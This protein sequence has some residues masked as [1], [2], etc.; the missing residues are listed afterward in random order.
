MK[1]VVIV[2]GARTPIGKY[3]GQLGQQR[4]QDLIAQSM[5]AAVERAGLDSSEIEISIGGQGLQSSLPANVARHG[6]LLAGLS[7]DTA[8][9]TINTLCAGGL[10]AMISSFNKLAGE[11]YQAIAVSGVESFS[12]AQHYIFHPR[13][14]FGPPSYCFH[15]PKIEIETNAQPQDLYGELTRATLADTIAKNYGLSRQTIDEYTAASHARA[16]DAAKKELMQEAIVP[17][18]KKVKKTEVTIATDEG[19]GLA[20]LEKLMGLPSINPWGSATEKNTANLAD[21]AATL[22]M[23]TADKAKDSG[24]KPL[25]R[26]LGFGVAAGNPT[27]LERTTVD[28]IQKALKA[29]GKK[30]YEVDFLDL[31]EPSAA[32]GVIVSDLLGPEAK[33][34][35]NVDGSSLA[36]GHPGAATGTLMAVNMIYRLQRTGA[37]LGL[38]NVGALG[39]QSLTVVMEKI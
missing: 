5:K 7:E 28:S 29:A 33:G 24:C 2:S 31:H 8:G 27:L 13:Y 18:V 38:V 12:M 11:E 26:V 23:L 21:G 32:Y 22:V 35:I 25:A 17:V 36:Y 6:W 30:L 16:V 14:Q 10:Q 9:F 1:E 4:S 20:T 19:P 34:R 15:D 37:K 39:G 3:R